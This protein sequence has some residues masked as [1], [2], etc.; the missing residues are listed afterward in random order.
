MDRL[1]PLDVLNLVL[2]SLPDLRSLTCAVQVSKRFHDA[3]TLHP[4]SI[5]RAVARNEVGPSIK[6]ARLLVYTEA[7]LKKLGAFDMGRVG[8]LVS[9]MPP[10]RVI[11]D[12]PRDWAEAYQLSKKAQQMRVIERFYSRRYG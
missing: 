6:S 8:D 9:R 2:S 3:Y 10:E 5:R 1:L 11:E 12:A 4:R 7:A